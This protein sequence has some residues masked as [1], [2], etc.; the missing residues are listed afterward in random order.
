MCTS[1]H[2]LFYCFAVQSDKKNPTSLEFSIAFYFQ[3]VVSSCEAFRRN[4]KITENIDLFKYFKSKTFKRSYCAG[5]FKRKRFRGKAEQ[6]RP[7]ILQ[8]THLRRQ[9]AFI[10]MPFNR[11]KTSSL[12]HLQST[13]SVLFLCVIAVFQNMMQKGGKSV[14]RTNTGLNGR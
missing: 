13:E 4:I 11:Q 7:L 5:I 1:A 2:L 8:L 3:K 12:F 14:K 6:K 9:H 10:V